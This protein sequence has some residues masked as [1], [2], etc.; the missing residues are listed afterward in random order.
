MCSP[1]TSKE[2]DEEAYNVQQLRQVGQPY[3]QSSVDEGHMG[4]RR[5]QRHDKQLLQQPHQP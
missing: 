2:V 3:R 4:L 5:R 1:Y